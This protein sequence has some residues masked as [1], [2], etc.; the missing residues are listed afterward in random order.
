MLAGV[1]GENMSYP[2]MR[3]V[4]GFCY[5]VGGT[6]IGIPAGWTFGQVLYQIIFL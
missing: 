1:M 6:F 2:K 4:V 3:L 5:L